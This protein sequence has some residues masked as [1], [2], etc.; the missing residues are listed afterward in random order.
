[1]PF[2]EEMKDIVENIVSSYETRIQGIEA[3]FDT[4]YQLLKGYNEL[5]LDTGQERG[6]VEAEL[7]ESL[8]RNSSLRR[9]DFDSM[10][11]GILSMQDE[12][13]KELRNLLKSYL[14]EQKGAA[15][16]LRDNLREFRNSL[17]IGEVQRIKKFQI[18]SQKILA[19]QDERKEEVTSKLKE[20]QRERKNLAL[21]LKNLLSKGRELRI[22]DLKLMLG[23]FKSRRNLSC[24]GEER[25]YEG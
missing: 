18:L 11:R 1:M 6:K 2:T 20:F 15:Q 19:R 24:P 4:T 17:V 3:V 16:A 22:N 8:A 7:R 23:E 25:G 12:R 14:N 5:S 9:K 21:R 13:E 10:M